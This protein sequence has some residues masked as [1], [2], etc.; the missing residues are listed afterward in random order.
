M[1]GLRI[2]ALT[3]IAVVCRTGTIAPFP[4][5]AETDRLEG[6]QAPL[7]APILPRFGSRRSRVVAAVGRGRRA[8]GVLFGLH[9]CAGAAPGRSRCGGGVRS[10]GELDGSPPSGR[11]AAAPV[12]AA[13][14]RWRC[15]PLGRPSRR[16]GPVGADIRVHRFQQVGGASSLRWRCPVDGVSPQGG[17][18]ESEG[19]GAHRGG[20]EVA[21][22][23]RFGRLRWP[24]CFHSG[25]CM[26]SF[27]W[28]TASRRLP[29]HPGYGTRSWAG[30]GLGRCLRLWSKGESMKRAAFG[31][32][33]VLALGLALL[34]PTSASATTYGSV[35]G[36]I[37]VD[38]HA[39]TSDMYWCLVSGHR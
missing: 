1:R 25:Q 4:E 18:G 34:T 33:A 7:H 32:S 31:V 20:P 35:S 24:G 9:T 10:G 39:P 2:A 11:A 8:F 30:Q 28:E 17:L 6:P 37:T 26:F 15:L 12:C 27:G 16:R 13:S 29:H 38:G 19:A 36:V 14:A 22:C 23:S 21:L 3:G 5:D